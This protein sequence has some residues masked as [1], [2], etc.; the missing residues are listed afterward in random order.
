MNQ[1]EYID[2]YSTHAKIRDKIKGMH[3]IPAREYAERHGFRFNVSPCM[4]TCE[5]DYNRCTV[6]VDKDDLVVVVSFG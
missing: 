3:I 6:M 5:V 1:D 4:Q 2:I